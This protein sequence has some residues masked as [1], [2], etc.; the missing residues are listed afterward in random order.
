MRSFVR[1]ST[2]RLRSVAERH[3]TLVKN[4]GALAIGTGATAVLGFVYWWL[5]A[6]S[7]PPE[8]I[9]KA[10]A[11][12]ALMNLVGIVGE[13]GL[14]TLLT[15]EIVRRPDSHRGLIAAAALSATLLSFGAGAIGLLLLSFLTGSTGGVGA[16]ALAGVW[17]IVGSGLTGL[18]FVID[19]AFVGMLRSGFRM[20]RQLLFAA[21]KLALL[22]AAVLLWTGDEAAI[23]LTW[24]VAQIGSLALVE[25]LLGWRGSS[26]M[27]RPDF[28]QLHG[29]KRKV[30]DHYMLDLSLQTPAIVMPY[31]VTVLLS[32]TENAAFSVIWLIVSVASVV[33]AALATVL[34]PVIS[35]SPDQY[36]DKMLFSV[37]VSLAFSIG[38]SILLFEVSSALLGLFNP[39]YA[40]IGGTGLGFLGFGLIGLVIKFHTCTAA[41]VQNRMRAASLWFLI[42]GAFELLCAALGRHAGGLDGL[43]LG[44]VAGVTVEG[45]VMLRLAFRP[46]DS[47]AAGGFFSKIPEKARQ[48]PGS[49]SV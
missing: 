25:A 48:A 37:A 13:A 7:F 16:G 46:A 8:V 14:G 34:F 35:A 36:R 4:S 40:A 30:A 23:L 49:A 18:S 1:G 12:L 15:G 19:E 47:V 44:W 20:L 32:P 11:L 38:G 29:L 45:A 27:V 17:L 26:L 22:G 5:A 24:V 10:S 39:L 6:R 33:P 2:S 31:V 3:A 9:G 42:G 28:H 41:R 21:F 43:V